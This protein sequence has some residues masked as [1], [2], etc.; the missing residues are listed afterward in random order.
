[1]YSS[2]YVR[3]CT[4]NVLTRTRRQSTTRTTRTTPGL[5]LEQQR[6]RCKSSSRTN[7]N[8][9]TS[10]PP[11]NYLH[12]RIVIKRR[13]RTTT[14]TTGRVKVLSRSSSRRV[15]YDVVWHFFFLSFY[16]LW[17]TFVASTTFFCLLQ[18]LL[19]ALVIPY[20]HLF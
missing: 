11:R 5:G 2:Y 4:K 8:N 3:A 16:G 1:M 10:A 6:R 18:S 12:T 15:I 7:K 17:G 19:S 14:T 9:T 20:T 13:V